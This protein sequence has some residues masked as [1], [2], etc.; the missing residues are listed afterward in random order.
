MPAI[1]RR[2]LGNLALNMALD[3]IL[4]SAAVVIAGWLCAPGS[5]WPGRL[6]LAVVGALAVWLIGV[7]FG[8]ARLHWRY[9]S[10][11]DLALVGG[12]GVST[13]ILLILLII[14][15]GLSLPS[16]SYPLGLMFSMLVCLVAPRIAYRLWRNTGS[17]SAT[18][19]M[20]SAL[21]VGNGETAELFLAALAW[22]AEPTYRVTGLMA[23]S[24]R[25]TGR[26]MHG[27]DVIGAVGQ[28]EQVLVGLAVSGAL[29][30]LLIITDPEFSGSA[31]AKV[32]AAADK[33]GVQ[34]LRAP[35]L[36]TL[37]P[38][39]Q[40]QLQ[41]QPIS[42]EDL[43]NRKQVRLDRDGM[44]RLIAGRRVMVTG[45]GGSI[46]AELARQMAGFAPASLMLLDNG[47]FALWQIDLELTENHPAV[48]R[49]SV[50]ADVRDE[51]RMRDV[52]A[53]FKPELVFHA[54]AL[55]HVPI[56]EANP[57]EGLQ[58]NVLGTKAVADAARAS[59]AALMV[60]ISTDKA[61]N[62]S[63]VMGATKRLAELYCQALDVASCQNGGMG[64]VTVRFGNVLGST[65]SVV[66][67]FHRQLAKGGPLTVT[68]PDMQRYFMTV[69]EAVGLVLQASVVGAK[70]GERNKHGSI[71]VLDMGDPVRIVDLARQMIRLAGLRPDIDIAIRFT[72]LR[73]GEKLFE[74]LFH[75]SERPVPTGFPGLLMARPRVADMAQVQAAL[76]EIAA[77]GSNGNTAAALAVLARLVPEFAHNADGSADSGE[78]PL[79][80]YDKAG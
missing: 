19:A 13:A 34:V 79:A 72:G 37:S 47:E 39:E 38:A 14:G 5:S 17:S 77:Q 78:A 32:L 16:P 11:R 63:S 33:H 15:S 10:M 48:P 74:E 75:G 44:A 51:A 56:V 6:M 68:H 73:P 67:L 23:L 57:L 36:T 58:T 70:D 24:A 69:R 53:E 65:G 66:P 41:L 59:G 80:I 54:A 7:P 8:L 40:G 45:A 22:T 12:A 26:R 3:G 30:D 28:A 18:K 25:H 55:K 64:C 42:I 21:L 62:P 46:G 71:F 2:R 1:N 60:L 29:P 35:N 43:L 27:L 20:T 61:V 52:C 4:A 31:L 76:A 50:I 9:T 49:I